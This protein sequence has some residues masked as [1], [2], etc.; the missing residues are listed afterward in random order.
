MISNA[1]RPDRNNFLVISLHSFCPTLRR[2]RINRGF[3]SDWTENFCWPYHHTSRHHSG[4]FQALFLR[5]TKRQNRISQRILMK[6]GRTFILG[7][8]FSVID[9]PKCDAL[10]ILDACANCY[11]V[12]SPLTVPY[13]HQTITPLTVPHP[14]SPYPIFTKPQ[15]SLSSKLRVFINISRVHHQSFIY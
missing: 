14:Y 12:S 7:K 3:P 2:P 8:I 6:K 5:N 11:C 4:W 15:F 10:E 1:W 9:I 13:L